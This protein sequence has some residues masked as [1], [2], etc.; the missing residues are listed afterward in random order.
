[1]IHA[2]RQFA[3]LLKI[4][5]IL[6]RYRLDEFLAATHLYRPMRLLA[7]L[8]PFSSSRAVRDMPR[9][10]RLRLALPP[11]DRHSGLRLACQCNVL[12][13]IKV[14]KLPGPFGNR[15]ER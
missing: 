4:S 6:A 7:V 8:T 10:Q 13:D 14:T 5:A 12:G 15:E 11:H 2:L 9:G 3:R 1:M